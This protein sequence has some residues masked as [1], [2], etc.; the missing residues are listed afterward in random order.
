MILALAV[1]SIL[2]IAGTTLISVLDSS[3]PALTGYSAQA[4]QTAY[5]VFN[6]VYSSFSLTTLIPILVIAGVTLALIIASFTLLKKSG[7]CE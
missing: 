5:V 4:N 3:L 6:N 7:A 2:L 1:S